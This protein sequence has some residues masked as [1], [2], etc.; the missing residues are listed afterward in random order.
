M[1]AFIDEHRSVYGV[2]PICRVLPI[3][4]ST[5]YAHAARRAD[6]GTL[7]PRAKCDEILKAHIRRVFE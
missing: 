5:S 4:P 1:S 3:A 6:P 7:S 2:E